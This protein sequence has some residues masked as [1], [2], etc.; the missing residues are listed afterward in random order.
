MFILVWPPVGEE[1]MLDVDMA[2]GLVFDDAPTQLCV[3]SID[4]AD[5]WTP[6]VQYESLPLKMS[7]W[8]S[9]DSDIKAW[10]AS[11]E[12]EEFKVQYFDFSFSPAFEFISGHLVRHVDL[13][14]IK[15][16]DKPFGVRLCFDEDYIL[17]TPIADGGTVETR[18][19]NQNNNVAHFETLGRVEYR[20]AAVGG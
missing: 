19:F 20:D 14:C 7:S 12:G 1:N 16:D 8:Q 15:N 2:L 13:V 18:F 9:F 10:M 11:S 6:C 4:R 17:L 5:I 3:I